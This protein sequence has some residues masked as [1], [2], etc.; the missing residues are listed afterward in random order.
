M[1]NQKL[2]S[3]DDFERFVRTT[4]IPWSPQQRIVLAVSMVERWLPV[5]ESFSKEN[6]WGDAATFQRTVQSVWNCVLGH[7]LTRKDRQLYEEHVTENTPD[8]DDYE[9]VATSAMIGW[10]LNCCISADNTDEAVMAMVCGFEAV[11]RGIYQNTH[12]SEIEDKVQQA[13]KLTDD[14][15]ESLRARM[16]SLTTR[17]AANLDV[18][19]SPHVQDELE[20]QS[21][22]LKLIGD[23]AQIDE[24]QIEALRQRLASPDLVGTVAPR[25]ERP[26]RPV[27]EIVLE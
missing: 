25:P 10:A 18:W 17:Q 7:E 2:N 16:V 5:Y 15:M 22:L 8:L 12:W 27:N 26:R 14:T 24:Q 9:A 1:P 23:M 13:F 11:A 6:Q 19:R 4:I 20:K 21:K 3:L